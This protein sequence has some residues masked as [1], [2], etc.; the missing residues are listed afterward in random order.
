MA[1]LNITIPHDQ[2]TRLRNMKLVTRHGCLVILH[3]KLVF[4]LCAPDA[5]DF[6]TV[7]CTK[8]ILY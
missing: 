4:F 7:F 2:H 5:N 6:Y 8:Y 1:K 3:Y